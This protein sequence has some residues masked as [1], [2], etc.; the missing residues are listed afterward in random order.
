MLN[1]VFVS[2]RRESE[3]HNERVRWLAEE[4]R[5]HGL[6]VAFDEF[7]L[8][9]KPGGPD[10]KW[11]RWCIKQAKES[12]CV[13]IVGSAGWYTAFA[14]PE[15]AE[16]GNGQG[17]AA[18]ANVIQQQLY[19]MGWVTSRHRVILLDPSDET[20][21]PT[22]IRGWRLVFA[23]TNPLD[24]YDLVRW[25]AQ[26]TGIGPVSDVQ[27]QTSWPT[28][29][30]PFKHGLAD[31]GREWPAVQRLL[32]AGA[33]AR[34]LLFKGPSN[35]S[36]SALLSAAAR[37]ARTLLVPTA[38]VDFKVK[39]LL[40]ENNMLRELQLGLASAL[41][42]FSALE[43]PDWWSL[44]RSLRALQGPVVIFLDTYENAAETKDL[45]ERIE[46]QLLGEVEECEHLRFI[47]GGQK[48][49][50]T[51]RSRWLDH[52]ELVELDRVLDKRVWKDWLDELNPN[53]DEKHIE[54]IVLGLEGVPGT[55]STAL[56]TCAK[57]ITP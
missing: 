35:F 2:Y 10:E 18:E 36:K 47:I 49:P 1:Q 40:S 30:A 5:S 17:V 26:E 14:H 11:S 7:Y 45:V 52:A 19:E 28:H 42:A 54:G 39:G 56:L 9:D 3:A 55:I 38:Y 50:D 34:I 13:L 43:E 27:P 32:T 53:V 31:L 22:E 46:T 29:P 8:K 33:P 37:Y 21:L 20:G 4:L 41:P 23:K 12:A 48:V 6:I 25:A 51:A 24:L 15:T 57:K 44:R 16:C